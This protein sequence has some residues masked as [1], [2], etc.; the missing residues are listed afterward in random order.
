[1]KPYVYKCVHKTT[2]EFYF[3]YRSRNKL[4]AERDLGSVYFTSSKNVRP[5]FAEFDYT[6]LATFDDKIKAH[7][8][9]QELIKEHWNDPL[10]LNKAQ[11]P[12]IR[13]EGSELQKQKARERMLNNNPMK[14]TKNKEAMRTRNL[15]RKL[16]E[17]TKQ[18]MSKTRT[19][20][21]LPKRPGSQTGAKNHGAKDYIFTSPEGMQ[22]HVYG[23]FRAFCIEHKLGHN[24][25]LDVAKGRRDNY[26]GWTIVKS[27]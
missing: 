16:P 26:K 8:Y 19:G 10:L 23:G 17:K 1:M 7:S 22:Y 3:G 6:I 13:S 18:K 4:P 9:E 2:G 5:R 11:F 12:R 25:C 27:L 24:S 15:G 14:L 20:K 21:V